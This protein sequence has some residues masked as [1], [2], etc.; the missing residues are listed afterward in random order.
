M[1]NLKFISWNLKN[2]S[3]NKLQKQFTAGFQAL[4]MGNTVMDYI[5]NVVLGT[6]VWEDVISPKPADMFVIIELKTGGRRKG[7]P[8]SGSC[9]PSLT[10]VRNAL[11]AAIPTNGYDPMEYQYDFLVPLVAGRYETMGFLY[12]TRVFRPDPTPGAVSVVAERD[13][14]TN[15]YLDGRTP[16]VAQ[17]QFVQN[18]AVTMRWSAI[19]DRP[20]QGAANIRF[21]PPISFCRRL[22]NTPSAAV[23][24]TFFL[25]DFNCQPTNYYVNGA[26][27]NVYPF[28]T[29]ANL[30]AN[31][32]N[33]GTTLPDNSLT[34][35][36]KSLV[37]PPPDPT[38][39]KSAYLSSPYDNSIYWAQNL[40]G[41]VETEVPD[42]IGEAKD[43]TFNP[44]IPLYPGRGRIVLNAYNRVS[45][46]M[47][48]ITEFNIQV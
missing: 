28:G 39:P 37:N 4:G 10:L 45:D 7:A 13:Q 24:N 38:D 12:N 9:I 8:V 26:G 40:L 11:N 29:A 46:H 21:R 36:R 27:N 22:P 1:P 35:V 15:T 33:Y 41:G 42:L 30:F 6:E 31:L 48:V 18:P 16:L 43:H 17:L 23:T 5:V 14:V 19:H 25:G 32:P 34:S 47:P 2:V 44:P 20:P 3:R